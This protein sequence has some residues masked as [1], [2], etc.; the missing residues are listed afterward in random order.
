MI[1]VDTALARRLADG[2]PVRAAMVSAGYTA[3]GVALRILT[4]MQS[5]PFVAI[6]NRTLPQVERAYREAGVEPA[7]A[8]DTNADLE[9]AKALPTVHGCL[10]DLAIAYCGRY[11]DWESLWTGQSFISGENAGQRMLDRAGR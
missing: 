5:I 1:M 4:A 3:R 2:N 10:N 9:R 11:G 7:G 6:S 8:V